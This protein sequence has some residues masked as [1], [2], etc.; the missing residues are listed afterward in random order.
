MRGRERGKEVANTRELLDDYE[1]SRLAAWATWI[2]FPSRALCVAEGFGFRRRVRWS[3]AGAAGAAAEEE[4]GALE[5]VPGPGAV[6][7]PGPDLAESSGED[8]LQESCDEV[9]SGEGAVPGLAGPTV[10][11]AEGDPSALE[12]LEAAVG[13]SDSV[14]V[15]TEVVEDV[16]AGAG[17]LAMNDPLAA[18]ELAGK[19]GCESEL[20]ESGAYFGPEDD[21]ES[22][23]GD[24]EAA[25]V[26]V[27]PFAALGQPPGGAEEVDVRVKE[28]VSG[29]GVEHPDDP[30]LCP[31]V[32]RIGG[33]QLESLPRGRHQEAVDLPL[34]GA[35]EVTQLFGESEGQKEVGTGQEPGPLPV[36]PA[37]RAI[38]AALG[39]MPIAA[40]MVAVEQLTTLVALAKVPTESSRATP[41]DV[42]HH[43]EVRWQH[44]GAELLTI[45]TSRRAEDVRDLEHRW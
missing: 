26:G 38:P 31:E 30:G 21:G 5:G 2:G 20:C 42:R 16:D 28:Q 14:E 23:A 43:F 17:V 35:C 29:P 9:F 34:V 45:G 39:T 11:V 15:S 36:E 37:A 25:M 22:T 10:A 41:L 4:A 18:P 24:E 40:G 19:T 1:A 44:A 13:E 3:L 7:T 27:S 8:V 32:S 12:G 33:Q 6:Q